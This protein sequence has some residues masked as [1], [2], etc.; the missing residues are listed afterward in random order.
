MQAILKESAKHEYRHRKELEDGL[1]ASVRIANDVNDV[2]DS[3][4]KAAIVRELW[5]RVE[6][7]K[8]HDL[9]SFGQLY[10]DDHFSVT[11]GADE[12]QYHI[13]LFEK[14]LL[15]CKEVLPDR[16][17]SKK[18]SKSS[19]MLRKDKSVNGKPIPPPKKP[20]ALKGRIFVAN[21]SQTQFV[22]TASK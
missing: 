1:A 22:P 13:F 10:M 21:I 7:W 14:M 15:C 19:S 8:G 9:A 20:L 16:K 6:D 5:E 4:E 18:M 11:K 3:K 17:D 12:R 2:L